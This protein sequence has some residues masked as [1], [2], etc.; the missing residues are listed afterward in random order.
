MDE[1][2]GT[3]KKKIEK[4]TKSCEHSSLDDKV[5]FSE[6]T[7]DITDA[8]TELTD[9]DYAIIKRVRKSRKGLQRKIGKCSIIEAIMIISCVMSSRILYF[10]LAD[11]SAKVMLLVNFFLKILFRTI[12]LLTIHRKWC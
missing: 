7:S 10:P 11:H 8:Y 6:I 12:N 5:N 3:F 2:G 1:K 4:I 9:Q